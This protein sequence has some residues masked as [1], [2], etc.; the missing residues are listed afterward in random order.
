MSA[1]RD[2][3][4]QALDRA[5]RTMRAVSRLLTELRLGFAAICSGAVH[6]RAA[7]LM[8]K[9]EMEESDV[10]KLCCCL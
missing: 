5:E 10:A 9:G 1:A 6:S 7:I 2:L 8:D 3:L 4:S